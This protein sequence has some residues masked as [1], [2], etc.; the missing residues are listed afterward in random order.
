MIL[1]RTY[2]NSRRSGGARKLLGSPQA[3]H[4]A[5]LAGFPPDSDPGRILWR[6]DHAKSVKPVVYIVSR[7]RPDLVHLDEQAGWPSLPSA[8]SLAYDGFLDQ[9]ATGQTWGGFRLTANPAHHATE[10]G[11][12]RVYAHVTAAQQA[13]WLLDRSDRLGGIRLTDPR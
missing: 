1:T 6:V 12:K 4:A 7:D 2:L 13:T 10:N 8:S 3:M 11:R 5:L 9:L